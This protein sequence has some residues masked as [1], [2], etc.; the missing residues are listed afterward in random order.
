M[1]DMNDATGLLGTAVGLG[2][3][4]FFTG[5]LIDHVDKTTNKLIKSGKQQ[6]RKLQKKKIKSKSK[7]KYK[8][9]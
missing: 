2:A 9:Y 6:N 1:S 4:L 8:R 5:M 7:S 3:T